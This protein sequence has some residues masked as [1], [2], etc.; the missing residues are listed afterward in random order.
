MPTSRS[1]ARSVAVL[2]ACVALSACSATAS[3]SVAPS[4]A[5]SAAANGAAPSAGNATSEAPSSTASAAP[6][7]A[8]TPEPTASPDATSGPDP[9]PVPTPRPTP[10]PTRVAGCGTGEAGYLAAGP[11]APATLQFGHATI[12]F[13]QAGSGLRDGSYN[14]DDAIPAGVGLTANEIAVV[15]AP[16]DHIILRGAGITLTDTSAV[17]SPWSMVT[18]SGGL[19]NLAGPTTALATR[20]RSDGS[21]SISA[22]T[23]IGDWAVA[24][25]PR[26]YGTCLKGDGTAYA[27][28]KVH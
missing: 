27:R 2:M 7:P 3:P 15:V 12:E 1:I 5:L 10:R 18:F 25:L 4:T 23:E 28:I 19:A 6:A 16:G 13:T 26:W 11:E 17:A 8:V 22:P 20:L 21:L 14:V 24:F 9:T